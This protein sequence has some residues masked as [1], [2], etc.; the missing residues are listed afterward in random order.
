LF[1]WVGST[2][3]GWQHSTSIN[4]TKE[5]SLFWIDVALMLMGEVWASVVDNHGISI[6]DG[7]T[8]HLLFSTTK[9]MAADISADGN[10]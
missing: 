3:W 4:T 8:H 9:L 2:A 1:S 7:G 10:V 5:A 6:K